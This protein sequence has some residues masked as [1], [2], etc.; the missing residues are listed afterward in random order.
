[1]ATILSDL[2]STITTALSSL[3]SPVEIQ[4]AERMQL[5][6]AISRLQEALETPAM[7]VQRMGL[8]VHCTFEDIL[9]ACLKLSWLTQ[10]LNS[11]TTLR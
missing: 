11:T 6:S 7:A 8:S 3:P 4:D 2:T 9:D 1:M 10:N 5:L